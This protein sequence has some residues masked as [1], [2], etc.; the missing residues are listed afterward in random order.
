MLGAP[1]VNSR[2][3]DSSAQFATKE[4]PS[5]REDRGGQSKVRFPDFR[6][7]SG[8]SGSSPIDARAGAVSFLTLYIYVPFALD[9]G[10]DPRSACW[11]GIEKPEGM[12]WLLS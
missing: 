4:E 8:K 6:P 7:K 3:L 11:H 10:S 1:K 9:T 12:Q 5:G 2:S